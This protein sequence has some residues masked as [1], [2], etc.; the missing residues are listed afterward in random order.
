M[1]GVLQPL[2][3][4]VFSQFKRALRD[5]YERAC[6]TSDPG[7]VP[8]ADVVNMVF[9][10]VAEVL[11]AKNWKKAFRGV[12][13]G[14]GQAELGQRLRR[15]LHCGD[16]RVEISNDLPSYEDLRLAW[17]AQRW[18]PIGWLVHLDTA[19]EARARGDEIER[20]VIDE[21]VSEP[22]WISPWIGRL[23]SRSALAS[24]P[25][26]GSA[27]SSSSAPAACSPMETPAPIPPPP[28]P[29]PVAVRLSPPPRRFPV[30]RPL[31]GRRPCQ[32]ELAASPQTFK[33]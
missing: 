23:R 17:H 19:M 27:A 8:N 12:G 21:S 29:A 1:T 16:A 28:A 5:K 14:V 31:F 4:Y 3:V 20:P 32:R 10:C 30:G 24:H 13:L 25:A 2:D 6:H 11:Q 18:M 26:S 9:E 22:M 33:S 15:R 7:E